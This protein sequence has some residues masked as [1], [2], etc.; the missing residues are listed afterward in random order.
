M[1]AIGDSH[2]WVFKS[3]CDI[4][5][6]SNPTA[7]NIRKHDLAIR[8]VIRKKEEN[9]FSFGEIDCRIHLYRQSI[10]QDKEI[11]ELAHETIDRY[12]D[13]VYELMQDGYDIYIM[14]V[15]PAGTQSNHFKYNDYAS[16]GHRKLINFMFNMELERTCTLKQIHYIDYYF[17]VCDGKMGRKID[18]VEDDVHLNS[19]VADVVM[20][21][22]EN[23]KRKYSNY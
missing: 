20:E 11:V 23:E 12:T 8:N 22:M 18:Y 9:I 14:S 5:H 3:K 10:K 13:Y 17:K 6:I 21:I 16:Y 15:P 1:I 4:Y 19:K 7:H 2:T